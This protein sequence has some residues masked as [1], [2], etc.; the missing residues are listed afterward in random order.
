MTEEKENTPERM[1]LVPV[2]M[3][4]LMEMQNQSKE[5][6]P[7]V[8]EP[9]E[10]F[11]FAGLLSEHWRNIVVSFFTAAL[12]GVVVSFFFTPIFRA[13]ATFIPIDPGGSSKLSSM[14]SQLGGLGLPVPD[15]GGKKSPGGQLAVVLSSRILA[16][17]ILRRI[18]ELSVM[19]APPSFL[20]TLFGIEQP[21]IE[22]LAI[23]L[24]D[25]VDLTVPKKDDQ[26]FSLAV[27]LPNAT[28]S[29]LVANAFLE[30]LASYVNEIS[31]TNARKSREYIETQV[32]RCKT[33]LTQ[34]EEA[35]KYFQESHKL[36]SL[37][38]Q[39]EEA[40]KLV[41]SLKGQLLVKQIEREVRLKTTTPNHPEVTLLD[42]QITALNSQLQRLEAG[43]ETLVSRNASAGQNTAPLSSSLASAP[44]LMLD[45]YRHRRDVEISQ[46]VFEL[47]M[48]QLAMARINE[49]NEAV[50]FQVIDPAIIPWKKIRPKRSLFAFAGGLLGL[51]ACGLV[52]RLTQPSAQDGDV[53]P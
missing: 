9:G 12:V 51:L 2:D 6:Q 46:K 27:E 31:F 10:L 24:Q 19:I 23:A 4:T 34:S 14:L 39:A 5:S 47:L 25:M 48:Q 30:A 41:G 49:Q 8:E 16:E 26:P 35:L 53:K 22:R 43:T 28:M 45:Y 44:Q 13:E 52:L 29:A 21:P 15:M 50:T 1:V 33:E 40:I 32:S 20:S 17:E 37:D 18:P 42:D 36:V 7:K 11:P 38:A 3:D